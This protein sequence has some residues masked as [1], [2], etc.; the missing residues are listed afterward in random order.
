VAEVGDM[1]AGDNDPD[2]RIIVTS[3]CTTT[4]SISPGWRQG[5]WGRLTGRDRAV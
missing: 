3:G 4:P 1:R 2:L 5:R